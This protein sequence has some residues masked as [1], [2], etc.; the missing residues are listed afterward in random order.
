MCYVMLCCCFVSLLS[1]RMANKVATLWLFIK[2][3][4]MQ[5][6]TS[7]KV[8]I[9]E[10]RRKKNF[11][12]MTQDFLSFFPLNNVCEMSP[13]CTVKTRNICSFL[14]EIISLDFRQ[15]CFC[16]PYWM[17]CVASFRYATL[18]AFHL[19]VIFFNWHM[20]QFLLPLMGKRI[21][22]LQIKQC[23]FRPKIFL[24]GFHFVIISVT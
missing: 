2:Y 19:Q 7:S 14:P 4:W 1:C 12:W 22:G 18:E 10:K 8:I 16:N 23:N 21:I 17:K 3:K 15:M 11:W 24:I 20:T 13:T 9:L 5:V 6:I